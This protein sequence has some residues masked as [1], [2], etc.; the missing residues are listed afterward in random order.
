MRLFFLLPCLVDNDT[1]YG[2]A[3]ALSRS[4]PD[5]K[6]DPSVFRAMQPIYTARPI[7]RGMT[8]PVPE[9]S[10]VRLLDGC[11][12]YV[13]LELPRIHKAKKREAWSEHVIF[14]PPRICTEMSDEMIEATEADAGLGVAELDTS[15]KAWRAI[16]HI[17]ELLEGCPKAGGQGRHLTLTKAGWE[18]ACLVAEGELTETLAREAYWKAAE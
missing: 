13:T 7:F 9:W 10:R 14:G 2:W 5:L 11:E 8:D 6:L 17:F 1:L 3:D 16:K 12:D 15:D 18:L 4:R